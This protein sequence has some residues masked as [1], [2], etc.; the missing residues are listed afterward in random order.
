MPFLASP[1]LVM[2][3]SQTCF[4]YGYEE[5]TIKNGFSASQISEFKVCFDV[6]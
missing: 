2:V 4:V 1:A 3:S 6:V 5:I